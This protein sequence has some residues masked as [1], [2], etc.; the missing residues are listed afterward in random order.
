MIECEGALYDQN[1]FA[2][3][4]CACPHGAQLELECRTVLTA[5]NFGAPADECGQ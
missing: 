2:D 4:R 5:G 3:V 1:L